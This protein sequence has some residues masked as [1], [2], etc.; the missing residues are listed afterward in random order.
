LKSGSQ[1]VNVIGKF[2]VVATV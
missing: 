2:Q 1:V